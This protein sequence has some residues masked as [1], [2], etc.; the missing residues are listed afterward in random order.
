[1]IT[2]SEI[3]VE[4]MLY[5]STKPP[6]MT[7]KTITEPVI[8]NTTDKVISKMVNTVRVRIDRDLKYIS[9]RK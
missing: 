6:A 3:G 1:M 2:L 8:A 7:R 4:F 9:A 5:H